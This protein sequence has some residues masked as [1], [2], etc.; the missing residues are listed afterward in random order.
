MENVDLYYIISIH[1]PA[2]GATEGGHFRNV[3]KIFQFT[4]PR[5][6]RPPIS[7]EV[8]AEVNF[9]SRPREG[10]DASANALRLPPI[11]F[12]SRPREGGDGLASRFTVRIFISIHAPAKGATGLLQVGNRSTLPYFNSRPR[13]GGDSPL[14]DL[15]GD[16][17][18]FQFTPPRRGRRTAR[19]ARMLS[20]LFQ[21]T[22]PRRGRP[23]FASST[24]KKIN[25][26]IHAP[27]KGATHGEHRV[28]GHPGFQFTPPR[29][30]RR[31]DPVQTLRRLHFNSRPRE[32][33]DHYFSPPPFRL[34]ISIHAPAKG[35][36]G[37]NDNILH[38]GAYFNSRPREG[39]DG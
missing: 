21:F 33:G 19:T 36:T 18:I 25:I 31:H 35:A 4:P 10:G 14:L 15:A 32:G 28:K 12:N 3:T 23:S 27:A 5:R 29:R 37:S 13:E 8:G 2:K 22:P 24:V 34:R 39:G 16:A 9:N 26:S 6:G 17:V 1:A 30:G 11:Y 20:K 7:V 38:L